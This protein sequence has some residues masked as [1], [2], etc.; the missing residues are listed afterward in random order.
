MTPWPG[1]WRRDESARP[2]AGLWERVL[3]ALGLGDDADPEEP[4]P[5]ASGSRAVEPVSRRQGG[6]AV[7]SLA[8]GRAAPQGMF[9]TVARPRSIDEARLAAEQLREGR[10]VVLNLHDVDRE[11]GRRI[12]DFIGGA[13]YAVGGEM[14][15]IGPGVILMAPGSVTVIWERG[16]PA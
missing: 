13:V 14:H 11:A 2:P 4:E 9:I 5:G 8:A 10:P 6:R 7:V 16:E 1:G 15:L 12:L 3:N